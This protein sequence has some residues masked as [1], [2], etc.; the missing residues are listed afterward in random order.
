MSWLSYRSF[1]LNHENAERI[2]RGEGGVAWVKNIAHTIQKPSGLI[3][4]GNVNEGERRANSFCARSSNWDGI[5]A[6]LVGLLQ[7]V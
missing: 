3:L 7:D 1:K 6:S 5:E 4:Y 2:G